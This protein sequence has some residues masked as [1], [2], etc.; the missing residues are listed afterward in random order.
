M[1]QSNYNYII[2]RG[3]QTYWFNGMSKEFFILS[4]SLSNKVEQQINCN[5]DFL[6]ENSPIFYGKLIQSK[7][8]L[9]KDICETDLIKENYLEAVNSKKYL[10]VILPTLNCN[11]SC[12]YCIQDHV[13]T[14][15]SDVDIKKIKEHIKKAVFDDKI[16]SLEIQWFGGEPFIYFSDIIKPISEYAIKICKQANI[17]FSNSATTNGYYLT[18]Q[19]SKDLIKH[20]FK[21]FQIT[22][23][24]VRNIHNRVKYI[25]DRSCSTFDVVL[26]N[27]NHL[28]SVS[29]DIFV[30]LRLNYNK[31]NLDLKIINQINENINIGN[32]Y[33][34]DVSFKKLWQEETDTNRAIIIKDLANKFNQNGYKT[35]SEIDNG[36][37][38][39]YTDKKWYNSIN[40]NGDVVK[41][42]AN[43]D[44][45]SK[46]PP[47][48]LQE[49]GSIVWRRDYIE[50]YFHIRFENEICLKCKDLP[51]CMGKCNKNYNENVKSEFVCNQ[52]VD[53][54]FENRIIN[55][56]E[57]E[58]NN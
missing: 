6:K 17:P 15:M 31:K 52:N 3:E 22:L 8:I 51:L 37:L 34:I 27:I 21:Y 57:N 43:D 7:F 35:N 23:D 24:G 41:C 38:S 26:D 18:P 11:F 25:T 10:L 40:F 39:C 14:K 47:G 46:N 2:N 19:I 5:I 48:K 29:N 56:I 28:L 30:T 55:Y 42:T 53:I 16:E 20:Q 49:D 50:N 9:D 1:K 45:Y 12:W 44:L 58:D 4:S 13:N 54:D 36:C 33:K 32:R